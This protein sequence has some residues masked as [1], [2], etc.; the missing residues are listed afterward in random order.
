M[1]EVGFRIESAGLGPASWSQFQIAVQQG[2]GVTMAQRLFTLNTLG[3]SGRSIGPLIVGTAETS[4]SHH[5][6][7]QH[8]GKVFPPNLDGKY[9]KIALAGGYSVGTSN[10][11]VTFQIKELREGAYVELYKWEGPVRMSTTYMG[12]VSVEG[13]PIMNDVNADWVQDRISDLMS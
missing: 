2:R 12:G 11:T 3:T 13:T 10:V 4:G 9:L 5:L 1:P 7:D 6:P 8:E